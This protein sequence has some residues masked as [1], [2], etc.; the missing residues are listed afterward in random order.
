MMTAAVLA[1]VAM[2]ERPDGEVSCNNC[3]RASPIITL[4]PKSHEPFWRK[5]NA[6]LLVPSE[7]QITLTTNYFASP[8]LLAFPLRTNPP[9]PLIPVSN[10]MF[11]Y[12]KVIA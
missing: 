4:V 5:V 11:T 10:G 9:Q 8:A 1:S 6:T 7:S 2:S 12:D 3:R